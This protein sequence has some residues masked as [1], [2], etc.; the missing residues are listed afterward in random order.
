MFQRN[1]YFLLYTIICAFICSTSAAIAADFH[2][3]TFSHDAIQCLTT[4]MLNAYS[5]PG[6]TLVRTDTGHVVPCMVVRFLLPAGVSA[7][8]L[9]VRPAPPELYP[10]SGSFPRV[11][12]VMPFGPL[13][14]NAMV[15]LGLAR[16]GMALPSFH[17]EQPGS[18]DGSA[19]AVVRLFP[20]RPA[21]QPGWAV[22]TSGYRFGYRMRAGVG[23]GGV[24]VV[25]GS[26]VS[27]G[28]GRR[29]VGRSVDLDGDLDYLVVT[30]A[31]LAPAFEPLVAWKN[32]K[33]VPA[34]VALLEDIVAAT[35]GRDDQEKIRNYIKGVHEARHLDYV[36]LGGDMPPVP[37]RLVHCRAEVTGYYS[38]EDD[39]VT[40]MYYSDL[41]G[42]WDG[43]GDGVFG[44]MEDGVDFYPDVLVGRLPVDTVAQAV[45]VVGKV[46]DFERSPVAGYQRDVM[47]IADFTGYYNI[48][49]S[50]AKDPMER[51]AVP[52]RCRP[53]RKLY[54]DYWNYTGAEENTKEAQIAALDQGYQLVNHFGHGSSQSLGYLHGT[55]IDQLA[56]G[57]RT[58]VYL[59]CA[60]D[61]G[62]FHK[63]NDG[64]GER[65]V[66]NPGGGGVAF[67]GNTNIGIGFPSGMVF[68]EAFLRHLYHLDHERLGAFVGFG[69]AE[70]VAEAGELYHPHRWTQYV[71]HLLGD[72]ELPVWTDD[73]EELAVVHSPVFFTGANLFH[74]DV[75]DRFGPVDV[76]V[77]TLYQ[78]GHVHLRGLTDPA[79]RATFEFET[80]AGGDVS[81]TVTSRNHVPYR[82]VAVASAATPTATPER[83]PTPTFAA[84]ATRTPSPTPSPYAWTPTLTPTYEGSTPTPAPADV[85]LWKVGSGWRY[86]E[87]IEV[88]I[89]IMGIEIPGHLSA[90][91]W[92]RVAE[93]RLVTQEKT[94][95]EYDAWVVEMEGHAEL[96]AAHFELLGFEVQELRMEDGEYGGEVWVRSDDLA[97]VHRGRELAG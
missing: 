20:L 58:G 42:D 71:L 91:T 73:P 31:E 47:F 74:V 8:A 68:D 50:V 87:N 85:P 65:W 4:S 79:G 72:P 63:A 15:P 37:A 57:A 28:F 19:V 55:E 93:R 67:V 23:G 17:V 62:S 61:S 69:K 77:V 14:V 16:D 48:Y 44:E 35:P 9:V 52:I 64:G 84:T 43:D 7:D 26:G 66:L 90:D 27:G 2:Q 46:L 21:P 33:G 5:L 80:V 53:V 89:S 78:E 96:F 29:L 56:N 49:S 25:M 18:M 83:S 32:E 60:C 70:F 22:F 3:V 94:G 13:F 88:V 30:T 24:P 76:A 45:A 82:G 10:L 86:V 75:S 51:S 41:D 95:A 36:L 97:L 12:G 54:D 11:A 6:C 59:S 1:A 38:V 92:F 40:D 81:V 34:A 39:V